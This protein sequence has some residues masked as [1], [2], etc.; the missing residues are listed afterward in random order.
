MAAGGTYDWVFTLL[1]GLLAAA[2]LALGTWALFGD[3]ARRRGVVR[4]RCS[5]CWYDM[6]GAPRLICPECGQAIKGEKALLRT[7]RRWG[8]AAAAFVALVAGAVTAAVPGYRDGGW[9][10]LIPT[11]V[12]V[13]I[14]PADDPIAS[15]WGGLVGVPRLVNGVLTG[16]GPVGGAPV[17]ASWDT[18]CCAA[19]WERLL[20]GRMFNWQARV[21]LNRIARRH[22]VAGP[23]KVEYVDRWP[24][25]EPLRIAIGPSPGFWALAAACN[26]EWWIGG[27]R[28]AVADLF[29]GPTQRTVLAWP[30]VPSRTRTRLNFRMTNAGVTVYSGSFPLSVERVPDRVSMLKPVDSPDSNAAVREAL[31]PELA[32]DTDGAVVVVVNDR[33]RLPAWSRADMLLM[34]GI[35]IVVRGEVVGRAAGWADPRQPVWKNWQAL[36]IM[37]EPGGLERLLSAH[38]PVAAHAG[39]TAAVPP[40]P[41]VEIR[42]RGDAVAA[43]DWLF[44]NAVH[45]CSNNRCWTGMFTTP[46]RWGPPAR[47]PPP[48][49]EPEGSAA[50]DRAGTVVT[51]P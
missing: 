41:G 19:V 10:G 33:S 49:Y 39:G 11:T 14:A 30:S 31:D 43:A 51:P 3:R 24:A 48:K 40:A 16:V 36:P 26:S 4:R 50:G 21:Y 22:R 7:R 17:Q 29:P 8:R 6:A 42:V 27:D 28:N 34:F 32:R 2:G 46:A 25:D 45:T 35:E 5:K 13:M 23:W 20:A 9:I 1:G 18:R 15:P 38:P 44:E 37:W 12:L 47:P